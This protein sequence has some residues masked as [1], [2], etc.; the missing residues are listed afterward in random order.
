MNEMNTSDMTDIN[1][2]TPK[3][4]NC[5]PLEVVSRYRDPQLHVGDNSVQLL[6]S[7]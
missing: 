5:H 6:L 4:R 7:V 1:P 2:L 3:A